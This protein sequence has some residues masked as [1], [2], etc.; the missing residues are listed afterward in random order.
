MVL[1]RG[2]DHGRTAYIDV[3]DCLGKVRAFGDRRFKRIEIGYQ[4]VDAFDAVIAHGLRMFRIV[5]NGKKSAM[6][7]RVQRLHP[8]VHDFGETGH[9]RNVSN[10]AS[11][12]AQGARRA[13]G[14]NQ[15]NTVAGQSLGKFG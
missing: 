5:A 4:K 15:L 14:R 6:N 8:P 1:R 13:S 10:L 11:R 2:T 3:L 9:G 12:L 7:T